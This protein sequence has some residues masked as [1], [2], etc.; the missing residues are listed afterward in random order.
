M[1]CLGMLQT[2]S[3]HAI[4]DARFSAV[5]LCPMQSV[6][7]SDRQHNCSFCG[8]RYE[9]AAAD[10]LSDSH[11]DRRGKPFSC[12]RATECSAIEDAF[13]CANPALVQRL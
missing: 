3:N 10:S 7:S 9:V 5:Y 12:A 2:E 4:V 8:M 6:V 1:P 11:K 13:N